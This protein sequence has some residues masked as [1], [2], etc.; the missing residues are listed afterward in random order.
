MHSIN[1]DEVKAGALPQVS[2]TASLTYNPILQVNALPGELSGQ[3]GK[4]VLIAFGQKWNQTSGVSVSQKL[5]D[6][7]LFTGIK[8]QRSAREVLYIECAA[9]RRTGN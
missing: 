2:G 5:F 3:P 8:A 7:S 9:Y 1:P 4:T 6:K